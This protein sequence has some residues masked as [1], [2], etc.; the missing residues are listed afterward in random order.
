MSMSKTLRMSNS[1]ASRHVSGRESSSILQVAATA[2]IRCLSLFGSVSQFLLFFLAWP[3][4]ETK[5]SGEA[6]PPGLVGNSHIAGISSRKPRWKTGRCGGI[7][8]ESKQ[9]VWVPVSRD[10]IR[11]R[12][13]DQS[14]WSYLWCFFHQCIQSAENAEF[15]LGGAGAF[16][17]F[18]PLT[19]LFK[20][21][22]ETIFSIFGKILLNEFLSD[23]PT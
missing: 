23:R 7:G 19:E 20:D 21:Q 9:W 22:M 2:W 11:P 8:R 15:F 5:E 12:S 13:A 10:Q 1:G 6:L 17:K 18:Q 16:L 3:G 14:F 4:S